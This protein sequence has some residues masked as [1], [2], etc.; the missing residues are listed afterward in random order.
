M[1]VFPSGHVWYSLRFE[2]SQILLHLWGRVDCRDSLL[3]EC[4]GKKFR[5]FLGAI[6][7]TLLYTLHDSLSRIMNIHKME[8]AQGAGLCHLILFLCY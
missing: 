8:H 3:R 7:D 4:E 2:I 6:F 1:L 5:T